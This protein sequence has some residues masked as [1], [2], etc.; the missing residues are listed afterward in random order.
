MIRATNPISFQARVKLK[1]AKEAGELAA[2]SLSTTS[3][4]STATVINPGSVDYIGGSSVL[5]MT[6]FGL[7][8]ESLG[9]LN[10]GS[11]A[12]LVSLP[13]ALAPTAAHPLPISTGLT[14]SS[15]IA[16]V[17]DSSSQVKKPN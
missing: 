5:G 7:G 8:V 14:T 6:V 4:A 2:S 13:A 3:G 12:A 15:I 1:G 11:A 10:A 16:G 17:A 9:Q